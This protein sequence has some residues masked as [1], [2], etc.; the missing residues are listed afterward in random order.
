MTAGA[1]ALAPRYAQGEP[2]LQL[3]DYSAGTTRGVR[4][5]RRRGRAVPR[6]PGPA[7][8]R[9]VAAGARSPGASAVVQ[10]PVQP[11]PT[12]LRSRSVPLSRV[13][14][15]TFC[16]LSGGAGSD[17]NLPGSED[18]SAA[19]SSAAAHAAGEAPDGEALGTVGRGRG[20]RPRATHLGGRD[21][22]GI[23]KLPG[24]RKGQIDQQ[25]VRFGAARGSQS[26][27]RA[28]VGVLSG[29]GHSANYSMLKRAAGV[30]F[31]PPGPSASSGTTCGSWDPIGPAGRQTL[32]A[33]R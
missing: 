13:Q 7:A 33:D 1:P 4:P 15:G 10:C 6:A 28:G 24:D 27:V 14:S 31:G 3:N 19:N 12:P 30:L 18:A 26:R 2:A 21:S 29:H 23:R 22:S 20:T 17:I 5:G 32:W 25:L 11:N 16:K 9:R 8:R